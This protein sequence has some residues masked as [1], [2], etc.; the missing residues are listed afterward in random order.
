MPNK[1]FMLHVISDTALNGMKKIYDAAES[2]NY[3]CT[4]LIEEH[5]KYTGKK[6][7]IIL[8]DQSWFNKKISKFFKKLFPSI[9]FYLE[10]LIFYILFFNDHKNNDVKKIKHWSKVQKS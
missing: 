4:L 2:K 5:V 3:S 6:N 1:H 9:Q 10:K 8:I 7:K